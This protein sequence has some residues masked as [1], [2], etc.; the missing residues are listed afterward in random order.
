MEV[1]VKKNYEEMIH[2]GEK[3]ALQGHAQA[4]YNVGRCYEQGKGKEKDFK[5][6]ILMAKQM[7]RNGSVVITGSL[8][9]ISIVRN[10]LIH[11]E[12][13]NENLQ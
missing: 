5:K 7:H 10:L 2:W 11:S 8:Y 1:I 6:A 4:Q 13:F 12:T 9:F 3:A